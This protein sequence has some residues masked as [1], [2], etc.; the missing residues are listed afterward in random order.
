MRIRFLRL[1]KVLDFS[2]LED[3]RRDDY[4]QPYERFKRKRQHR[5][6][7][8]LRYRYRPFALPVIG[9][10]KDEVLGILTPKTCSNICLT[11]AVPPNPFSA[12]RLRPRSANR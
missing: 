7:H 4:A 6:H 9:E 1:E 10:D 2:D 11:R 3:A 5:A 8:R 12:R